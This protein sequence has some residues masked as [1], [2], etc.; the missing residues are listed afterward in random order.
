MKVNDYNQLDKQIEPHRNRFPYCIVWTPLPLITA[1][2]PFIGHTGICDADGV[3]H[4]FSGP[5]T[6]TVDDFAFGDPTKYI[7]LKPNKGET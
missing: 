5:Y 3:I 4:D 2:L 6:I 1:L 7:N